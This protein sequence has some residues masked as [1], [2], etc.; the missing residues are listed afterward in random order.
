[1]DASASFIVVVSIVTI[2]ESSWA[3]YDIQ[4]ICVH[5]FVC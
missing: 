3:A 4:L 5:A 1:M 2:D